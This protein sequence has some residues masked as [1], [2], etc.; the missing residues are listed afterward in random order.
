MNR[1]SHTIEELK[2]L[3]VIFLEGHPSR[4]KYDSAN[5]YGWTFIRAEFIF[6][7]LDWVDTGNYKSDVINDSRFDKVCEE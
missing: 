2:D 5:G 4:G 3:L 7:F 6:E 1:E